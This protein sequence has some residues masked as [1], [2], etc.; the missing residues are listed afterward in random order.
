MTKAEVLAREALRI[1]ERFHGPYHPKVGRSCILLATI[2]QKQDELG[3]QTK[4]LFERSIAIF[5]RDI[6]LDGANTTGAYV[7]IGQYYIKVAKIQST[8]T[9]SEVLCRTRSSNLF[10]EMW[11]CSS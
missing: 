3:D 1:R 5:I 4:K 10:S 9:T 6:G 8:A 11:L 7:I 2:L